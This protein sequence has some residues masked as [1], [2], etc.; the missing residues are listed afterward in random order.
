MEI[1]YVVS[2]DIT[3]GTVTRPC[4]GKSGVLFLS[5]AKYFFFSSPK[6][7]DCIWGS[8]SFLFNG[9]QSVFLSLGVKQLGHRP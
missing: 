8:P 6:C 1:V 9:Y 2:Q 3:V 5:Q 7:S 4:T